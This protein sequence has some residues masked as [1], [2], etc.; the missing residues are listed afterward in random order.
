MKKLITLIAILMTLAFSYSAT[1]DILLSEGFEH[2]GAIPIGWTYVYETGEE[3][4]TY[5][6]GTEG[7]GDPWSAHSGFYNARFYVGGG[8]A[9]RTKLVTANIDFGSST[10]NAILDF[11]HAQDA[12]SSDQDTL[13][14]FYSTTSNTGPWT[15]L[16]LYDTDMPDWTNHVISLPNPGSTYYIAFEGDNHY[17]YGVCLD[18]VVVKGCPEDVPAAP[19]SLSATTAN[20]SRIDLA[21]TKNGAGDD[22]MVAYNTTDTFGNPV[23]GTDYAVDDFLNPGTVVC[24]GSGTLHN[25][26]GLDPITHYYYKAFS[27]NA[28]NQYSSGVSANATTYKAEPSNYP[29]GFDKTVICNDIKLTWTGSTGA[30]LPDSYLIVGKTGAGTYPSI[31][32]GTPVVDD[33]DW[34][35]SNA[36]MNGAH[37]VGDNSYTFSG[38]D[39]LTTYDFRI[40][41]YVNTG[42]FIDYKTDGAPPETS[43]KTQFPMMQEGFNDANLPAG[44]V[45]NT[46][47]DPDDD[48]DVLL[49]TESFQPYANP[50]EGTYMIEFN[51]W[52]CGNGDEVRLE[53]PSIDATSKRNITVGFQWFELTGF[54]SYTD[55]GV[56]VQWSDNGTTWNDV[57]FIQRYG[58]ANEWKFKSCQLPPEAN[59]KAA[60]YIGL[61][62]HSQYG[63][64]CYLDDFKVCGD[65][66]PEPATVSTALGFDVIEN[67]VDVGAGPGGVKCVEFW[68]NPNT[69]TE[70][71]VDLD[72]GTH[73][74]WANTGTVTATGFDSPAIYVNGIETSTIAAGQWQHV[75]VTTNTGIN[76]NDLTMAKSGGNYFQ[77]KM[78]EVRFWGVAPSLST[79]R[80]WMYKEVNSLHPDWNNMSAY[81]KFNAGFETTAYDTGNNYDGVLTNEHSW[82]TSGA[83]AGP[84]NGLD[85][86]GADD[87]VDIGAGPDTVKTVAFWVYPSSTTEYFMDL[88][89]GTHTIWSNGGT[90]TATGFSNPTIYVNGVET[91]TIAANQWQHVAVTTDTGIN[92]GDLDI[93]A[94]GSNYLQGKMDEVRIWNDVR[95]A[96]EIRDNMCKSLVGNEDGLV[97]YYRFDQE[98]TAGQTTLYDI[99]PNG[100]NGDLINMNPSTDWVPSTA[101]NTWIGSE[102]TGWTTGGNWSRGSFPTSTDNVGIVNYTGGTSPTLSGGPTL[103]NFVIGDSATLTLNSGLTVT[104]TLAINNDLNLNGQ[105][106]TLGTSATL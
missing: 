99:T 63:Y 5:G 11:W 15:S 41:P 47:A 31:V 71:F 28:A 51:S 61:K 3:V 30:N 19:G 104:G 33:T 57:E 66:V 6:A 39:S 34:S 35:D 21:W 94:A 91:D 7:G 98:N 85:F 56:T 18:D 40:Y 101:F 74:I 14:V 48:A 97:A 96:T 82:I 32:D 89:G 86:D 24:N 2:D 81:Y 9:R 105:T 59:G 102:G 84:R 64:N 26:T 65:L 100:N 8:I 73:V 44:W 43:G 52:Y 87:Y 38:L 106:I 49:V 4:W 70:Y 68:V 93:G 58:P 103:N 36:A 16:A 13:E 72:G 50:Y 55:E 92:A 22:V 17:G 77:G 75:T 69:T 45:T 29:T 10:S 25:H 12:W 78:D 42:T 37:Q 53:S 1:A 20:S 27:V 62:F 83:F 79:I 88:D 23:H 46:L 67:Y 90:V 80:G 60:L 76:A 95:T 54:G